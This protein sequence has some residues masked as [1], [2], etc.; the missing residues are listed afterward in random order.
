MKVA[1]NN[2]RKLP[3]DV[4][5]ISRDNEEVHTSKFILAMFSPS[6]HHLLSTS[7]SISDS[8]TLLL[9]DILSSSIKTLVN[10]ITNCETK[11]LRQI[12]ENEELLETARMLNIDL[13]IELYRD[14]LKTE[15]SLA[16]K[17]EARSSLD[18]PMDVKLFD[19][20]EMRD[21]K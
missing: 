16:H 15:R 4:T 7:S 6:L 18:V 11:S 2:L 19:G 1:V 10:I 17:T 14:E 13:N 5:I 3:N 20:E 12:Q 8:I 21:A 9:P